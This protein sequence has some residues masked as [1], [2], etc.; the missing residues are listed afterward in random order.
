MEKRITRA[1]GVKLFCMSC[2]GWKENGGKGYTGSNDAIK[3]VR[4]CE[5]K[6]CYLYNF[7]TGSETTPGLAKKT[8]NPNALKALKKYREEKTRKA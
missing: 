4:E 3:M 7:R 6:E 2:M 5:S 1:K 8:V